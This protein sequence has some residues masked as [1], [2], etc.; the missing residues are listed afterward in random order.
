M[1]ASVHDQLKSAFHQTQVFSE[2]VDDYLQCAQK[3]RE[4]QV[5]N[6]QLDREAGELRLEN[7]TLL[8]AVEEASRSTASP[9]EVRFH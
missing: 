9:A 5:R 2:I 3:L 6:A 1:V 7:D 8:R 4:V